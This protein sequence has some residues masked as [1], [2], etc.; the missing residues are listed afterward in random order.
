MRLTSLYHGFFARFVDG[1]STATRDG[2]RG[3]RTNYLTL[4]LPHFENYFGI[5]RTI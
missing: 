1:T 3:E 5:D 2:N 4:A